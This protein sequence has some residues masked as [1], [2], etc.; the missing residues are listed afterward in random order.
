MCQKR[1][2]SI[3][4]KSLVVVFNEKREPKALFTYYLPL[5]GPLWHLRHRWYTVCIVLRLLF[6]QRP[7]DSTTG[8]IL[9]LEWYMLSDK[10]Y[11]DGFQNGADLSKHAI[12]GYYWGILIPQSIP[13]IPYY[14]ETFLG[15][16]T[17]SAKKGYQ[18]T[19]SN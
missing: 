15:K 19:K 9:A 16:N 5:H 3:N 14:G 4:S 12:W 1:I 10:Q 7:A 13:K 18:R 11:N 2:R 6:L 8:Y 17:F